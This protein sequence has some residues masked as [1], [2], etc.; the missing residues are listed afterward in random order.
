MQT[1]FG[2]HLL[3]AQE[4]VP[5]QVQ[6]FDTVKEELRRELS[7]ERA[8]NQLPDVATRLDDELAAGTPLR[9]GRRRKQ[10]IELLKLERIDRTGHTP[11]HERLAA[12]RLSAEILARVFAAAQGE[13]SLLE[14]TADGHYFMFRIDARRARARR[15]RWPTCATEVEAAWR[16]GGADQAGHGARGGAAAAGGR[17][18]GLD[19]AG[20][21]PCRH[22]AGRDRAGDPLGRRR[23]RKGSSAEAI[24]G[25]VRD[26]R[27]RGRRRRRRRCRAARAI[28]G[29]DE[30]IPATVDEQ[31]LDRHRGVRSPTR[32]APRCWAPTRPPCA[33]ATR[34]RST[35]RRW[36]S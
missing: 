3:R 10:G 19:A 23:A 33:S 17:R 30:V 11:S 8:A 22:P 5:E 13:T 9:R 14:Q 28:V 2:W 15:A 36:R 6:P 16:S 1:P 4:I 7:L 35:R 29:V 34:V 32:C 21:G 31:M 12:D 25:H 20:A 26:P 24:G 18:R 27:R